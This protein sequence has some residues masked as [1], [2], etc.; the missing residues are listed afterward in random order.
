MRYKLCWEG[1]HDQVGIW[2]LQLT[3]GPGHVYT[4]FLVVTCCFSADGVVGGGGGLSGVR[5]ACGP[6]CRFR[7]PRSVCYSHAT[8]PALPTCSLELSQRLHAAFKNDLQILNE[9]DYLIPGVPSVCG[10]QLAGV[11]SCLPVMRKA[12]LLPRV[13]TTMPASL[14]SPNQQPRWTARRPGTPFCASSCRFGS[15]SYRRSRWV[16]R[17][18]GQRA[19]RAG[20]LV[21]AVQAVYLPSGRHQRR[22]CRGKHGKRR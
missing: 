22:S 18:R 19:V 6:L 4:L 2:Q 12:A 11:Q 15:R 17:G 5:Q 9:S 7:E 20:A 8:L 21:N 14:L 1:P 16:G 13:P 3:F 10:M